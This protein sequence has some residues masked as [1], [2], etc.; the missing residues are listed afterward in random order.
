[1][2][3]D[4]RPDLRVAQIQERLELDIDLIHRAFVDRR[5]VRH[6]NAL[7]QM[8]GVLGQRDTQVARQIAGWLARFVPAIVG[9]QAREANVEHA[10][11]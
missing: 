6:A 9:G 2:E 4:R 8:A 3:S 5:R 11:T 10:E 1:M 7:A